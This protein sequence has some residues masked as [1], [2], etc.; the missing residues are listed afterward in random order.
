M[1]AH[2]LA[3]VDRL[4]GSRTTGRSATVDFGPTPGAV[5]HGR[6]LDA[7]IAARK[8]PSDRLHEL[9]VVAWKVYGGKIH[10]GYDR[11]NV[12]LVEIEKYTKARKAGVR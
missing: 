2:I 1:S 5:Q 9:L 11:V 4:I 3:L 7:E 8:L 6:L 10:G 12:L